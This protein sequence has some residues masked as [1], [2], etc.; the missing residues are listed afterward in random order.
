MLKYVPHTVVQISICKLQMETMTIKIRIFVFYLFVLFS[1]RM[2]NV[3]NRSTT[4]FQL[5]VARGS[6]V[7]EFF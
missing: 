2:N 1:N 5:S 6:R 7:D 4:L 3:V